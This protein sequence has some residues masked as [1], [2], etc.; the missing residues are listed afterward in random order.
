LPDAAALLVPLLLDAVHKSDNLLEIPSAATAGLE[1]MEG[2]D[3][4][5][6]DGRRML[7]AGIGFAYEGG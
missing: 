2:H 1:F 4:G 6:M 7:R 5:S 3:H